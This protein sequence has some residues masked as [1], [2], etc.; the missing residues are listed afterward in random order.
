VII[1]FPHR[2]EVKKSALFYDSFTS[3][4]MGALPAKRKQ[5]RPCRQ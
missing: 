3:E 4:R 1:D 5:Q 2:T